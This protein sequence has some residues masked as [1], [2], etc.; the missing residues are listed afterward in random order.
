MTQVLVTRGTFGGKP[1]ENQEFTMTLSPRTGKKG[2]Y[3]TVDGKPLNMDRNV[4]IM[5]DDEADAVVGGGEAPKTVAPRETDSEIIERMRDKFSVLDDMTH[6]SITGIV[7]GLIVTGPPG[8]GKSFGVEQIIDQAVTLQK[9]GQ[10]EN[11]KF[12]VEK[13]A[14]SP[15]GL[16]QLLHEYSEKGSLLVLDDS[17]TILY[18]E[19]S[20]NLLKA[21]LDSGKSRRLSWRSESRVLENAGIPES[22]EFKGSIIFI[23]N[24]DFEA[25]RGKIGQH[26]NAI[27]SRC[28]YLDMGI[29]SAHEKFLRCRQVVEDGML[30][31][32]GFTQEQNDEVLGFIRTNQNKLRE[33]S[34]RMVTK[35]ADLRKM[36]DKNW[37]RYANQTCLKGS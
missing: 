27:M 11:A 21:A 14:A 23:T 8:I 6:A 20:L 33:L 10:N 37:R 36:D 32:Y 35:V 2:P 34:L 24:L 28:H 4:R 22:F 9:M 3:V 29:H 12:G 31:R 13:G 5:L 26:L 7:R 15:I 16:F 1:I 18:D 25:T 30:R 17:D 19:T